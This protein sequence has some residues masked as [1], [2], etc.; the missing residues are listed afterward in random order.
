MTGGRGAGPGAPLTIRIA[1]HNSN[2][3][4]ARWKQR[5]ELPVE[6]PP[7][8]HD[9]LRSLIAQYLELPARNIEITPR[10]RR[11]RLT[12]RIHH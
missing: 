5:I 6:E 3:L 1:H 2:R 10:R 7:A 9:E 11:R 8:D 12:I 4:S